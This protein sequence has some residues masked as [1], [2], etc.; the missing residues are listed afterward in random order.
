[1]PATGPR[2][3]AWPPAVRGTRGARGALRRPPPRLPEPPPEAAAGSRCGRGLRARR[4]G[5]YHGRVGGV[6]G[7]G[8]GR[9]GRRFFDPWDWEVPYDGASPI[10]WS[11][12]A[13]VLVVRGGRVLL[14]RQPPAWRGRWSSPAAGWSLRSCCWRARRASATRRPATGSSPPRPRRC[15][16]RRYGGE[17]P[18]GT[19]TAWSSCSGGTSPASPTP[20]GRRTTARSCSSRGAPRRSSSGARHALAALACTARGGPGLGRRTFRRCPPPR[21]GHK[22]APAG[23]PSAARGP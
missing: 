13:N 12:R 22:G 7:G 2:R 6:A 14:V 18:A 23:A 8:A 16:C 17:R 21:R 1:M 20:R 4:L 10:R 9:A 11:V 15:T 5:R 3:M 19:P